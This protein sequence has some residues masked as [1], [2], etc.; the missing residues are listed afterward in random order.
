MKLLIENEH[1][2]GKEYTLGL[3]HRGDGSVDVVTLHPETLKPQFNLVNISPE[4]V[5]L[6][7]GLR[8]TGFDTSR[9]D[10]SLH[11]RSGAQTPG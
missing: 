2:G 8:G 5:Y 3:R 9:H 6:Y 10:G 7:E 1:S 11:L 4:G